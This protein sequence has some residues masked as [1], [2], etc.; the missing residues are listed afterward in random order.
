[1]VVTLLDATVGSQFDPLTNVNGFIT[2]RHRRNFDTGGIITAL[3][4]GRDEAARC[5]TRWPGVERDSTRNVD[6]A[7]LGR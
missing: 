7:D 3:A 5:D 6:R 2:C 4:T 1:L